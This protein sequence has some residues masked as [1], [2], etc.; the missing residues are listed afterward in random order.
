MPTTEPT[1]WGIHAG[2]TGDAETVF[3]NRKALR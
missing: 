2:K 3:M 1:A